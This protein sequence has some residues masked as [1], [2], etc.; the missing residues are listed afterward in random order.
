[1]KFIIEVGANEGQHTKNFLDGFVFPYY[2]G[3][4]QKT[5]TYYYDDVV[6]VEN[7]YYRCIKDN[8]KNFV[9]DEKNWK[10]IHNDEA[11]FKESII[12]VFE[13]N[14]KLYFTLIKNF[15]SYENLK[16]FDQAIDIENCKMKPFGIDSSSSSL[17]DFTDNI[18]DLWGDNRKFKFVKK[19]GVETIR[20]DK[21]IKDNNIKKIDYLWI[22]AQGSDFNVLKSLG[23]NTNIVNEGICEV[24]LDI[25]LYKSTNDHDS[26]KK[27]LNEHNFNTVTKVIH[28]GREADILFKKNKMKIIV[29][30]GGR[31][32][33]LRHHTW[34]KPKCL[35]SVRG[36]PLLYHLFDSFPHDDFIIIGDYY[37]EVLE[38][39]LQTNKPSVDYQLIKTENKGTIA[40]I[41]QALSLVKDERIILAWSDI[42]IN[43]QP[44]VFSKTKPTVITTSD[45]VCRWSA[46]PDGSLK[47]VP[48]STNGVSGL[49]YFDNKSHLKDLPEHGEFVKWFS[50]NIIDYEIVDCEN[51]EEL[52]DFSTIESQNDR[53]GFSRF[54]NE[55]KILEDTVEKKAIDPDYSH[56]IQKEQAWYKSVSDLGF[57][58]IPKIVSSE[59]FIMERIKGQHAYQMTDLS[60]R[61]KRAVLADYLD[62]LVSLHDL[63]TQDTNEEDVKDTYIKKTLDRVNSVSAI[64]PGFD[65]KSMTINGRKCKNIFHDDTTIRSIY[66]KLKPNYFTPI[67]GDPTFS[68]SLIDKNLR[69]WFI[70]P[71]GYFSKPGIWGDPQYD[72]AKVYYSAVGNYD[73]FNRRK[74][75]LHIDSETVEILMEES[76]FA[77]AGEEIFSEFFGEELSKIKILH[78]LIWLALSGY[79]KDDIDSVIGSFYLGLYYLE[80]GLN[81]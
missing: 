50:Q 44:N 34:N 73:A 58:R 14:R 32:S 49:F 66:E 81:K 23:S 42:I 31:G 11:E 51:L 57:R 1:M 25:S 40:G 41:N 21:H 59:P 17:Y 75:K 35:V 12:H 43:E 22:D 15:G 30:A 20:L 2:K 56:L 10:K 3:A 78:G 9:S 5:E 79:A 54:F 6:L 72:F 70:D 4:W 46:Q 24:S 55:V 60:E 28:R 8:T 52:G 61:E 76:H 16:I 62:A 26:V 80:E 53:A 65:Q 47:E 45:F 29:Q 18:N 39:Y 69:A 64:I 77:T 67:H 13:P 48:S 19:I 71:R 68:N 63:G 36:K 27:W 74:F 38:K 33:R 7:S 37:Y